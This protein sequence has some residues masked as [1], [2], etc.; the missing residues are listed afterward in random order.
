MIRGTTIEGEPMTVLDQ[1][2]ASLSTPDRV[3]S[4][5]G[6]L[7]FR[8]GAPTAETAETLFD[9]LTFMRGVDAFLNAFQLASIRAIR[10]GFLAAG[11]HDN[12]VLMFS[13]LM[14]SKSI[15]LTPNADTVYSSASST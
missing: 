14:D 12:Q 9:H 4:R 11:V 2:L 3:E 1:T 15:F 6:S 5:L 13:E 10:Q 7:E 8:D